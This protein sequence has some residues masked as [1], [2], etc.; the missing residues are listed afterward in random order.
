MSREKVTSIVIFASDGLEYTKACVESVL[1]YT[2]WPFELV[3][4]DTGA[5][6]G[7]AAYFDSLPKAK[8]MKNEAGLGFAK[9]YNQAVKLAS[10]DYLLFLEGNAVVTAN[11]LDN[12]LACIESDPKVGL[13]GPMSN[14]AAEGQAV[15]VS[16]GASIVAMHKFA[17][18]FNK[19]DTSK[20]I[21]IDVLAGFCLLARK[22]VVEKIGL[23][24]D[25]AGTSGLDDTGYC[26]RA[27]SAGFKLVRAGDTFVHHCGGSITGVRPDGPYAL[28]Q[29]GGSTAENRGKNNAIGTHELMVVKPA[30]GALAEQEAYRDPIEVYAERYMQEPWR[31]P[32]KYVES[33]TL[34]LV[35]I[36]KDD[37]DTIGRCLSSAK[38]VVDEIIVVDIGSTDRSI[39]IA[40]GFGA[41]IFFH[42]RSGDL[43]Q[44]RDVAASHAKCDWVMYLNADEELV[45]EDTLVVRELL[46]DSER[47]GFFFNQLNFVSENDSIIDLTFR[48]W[49]NRPE[50]RQSSTS[51]GPVLDMLHGSNLSAGFARIRVNRYAYRGTAQDREEI[52]QDTL[53]I[54]LK[55]LAR[56]PENT[57]A[58]FNLGNVYIQ[59]KDYEKALETYKKAFANLSSLDVVH[60][61]KLVRNLAICLKEIGR[62]R[63]AL[64]VLTDAK[65]A[66]QD[67]TDLFYIEGLIQVETGEY[68]AAIASF[69]MALEAGPSG[70]IYVSHPGVG[71]HVAAH[72][73]AKAYLAI[74]D[75][76]Q[77]V[78]EYRRALEYNPRYSPA[79]V[80]LGS[81]LMRR[82][83][84]GGLR[85]SLES[86][87]D[88]R[89]DEVLLA[90]ALV[91][92]QAGHH[93]IGLEYLDKM[94]GVTTDPSQT[95][96]LRG[97][98][99]LNAKRY[100]EAADTLG[101]IAASSRLYP[102]ASM[103]RVVCNLLLGDYEGAYATIDSLPEGVHDPIKELY[104]AL[105]D[106]LSGRK[107][108]IAIED[109][110]E[111]MQ[112]LAVDLMRKLLELG[113]TKI[114]KKA[115]KLL[116]KLEV[117]PGEASL[118]LGKIYYDVGQN[119]VAVEELIKAYEAG[120]ADGEAFFIL[121]RASLGSEFYEE[122][123]TFFFEALNNGV[124]EITLYISLGR[125]LTKLGELDEAMEILDA[126][127]QKY[128]ASLLIEQVRESVGV[129]V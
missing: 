12:L 95:S 41:K 30:I 120:C 43:A 110:R 99:L 45:S 33:P 107:V 38:D 86:C 36:V 25:D 104:R 117:S 18:R 124:E 113:E 76:K 65:E 15:R 11:W 29:A 22:S 49:R 63:E 89:A 42:E 17:K 21:E 129:F 75:E 93:E 102:S 79:L 28:A 121:G 74:G 88:I 125:T 52:G 32:D 122:A 19:R 34:S 23:L 4:V 87:V 37:E 50:Y 16:Y 94:T 116:D 109:N 70:R 67:Y 62:Y 111:E 40:K 101:D 14:L 39:D 71:G 47:E 31:F 68:A 127:A 24:P 112:R 77:A 48:L 51:T 78:S 100:R 57:V 72:Q 105:T 82:E 44:T 64:K 35:V 85:Q 92:S 2:R 108:S 97:Q 1:K 58:R 115:V 59:R 60:A 118:F 123:R 27:Q 126:G 61:S 5:T 54:L 80:E 73:L 69:G 55:E 9:L 90:L 81:I 53:T 8:V 103:D 91:F 3:L 106:T 46:E 114:F 7:T 6:D 96:L 98:C 10:G 128:P 56:K 119:D 83:G 66:Y 20:H 26:N 84:P 13:V